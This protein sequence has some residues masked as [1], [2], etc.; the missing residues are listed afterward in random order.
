MVSGTTGACA[1]ASKTESGDI[2]II[3]KKSTKYK[4]L[5]E[6]NHCTVNVKGKCL[7]FVTRKNSPT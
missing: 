4:S 1:K 3:K 6:I 7:I 5:T 2:R